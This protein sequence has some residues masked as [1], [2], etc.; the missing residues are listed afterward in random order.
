MSK[1][2][3]LDLGVVRKPKTHPF[4]TIEPDDQELIPETIEI[5][6][7][8]EDWI[9][10]GVDNQNWVMTGFQ[11]ISDAIAMEIMTLKLCPQIQ[12]IFFCPG[13]ETMCYQVFSNIKHNF[14][15]K[16]NA[17]IDLS[18]QLPEL[19]MIELAIKLMGKP[20]K[21]LLVSSKSDRK[22]TAKSAN[23]DFILAKEWRNQ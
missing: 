4:F 10:L 19:G 20:D 22:N 18:F 17:G 9:I 12:S 13:N 21:C 5:L 15:N 11:D 14:F 1:I 8:Y 23:I 7:D 3:F 2:L 6:K 16:K